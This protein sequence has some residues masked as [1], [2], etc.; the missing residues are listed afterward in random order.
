MSLS[1]C[2]YK[3]V[4]N[5]NRYLRYYPDFFFNESQENY[6]SWSG[7]AMCILGSGLF[8]WSLWYVVY[9]S[10]MHI[11]KYVFL[12][13]F[14]KVHLC[15]LFPFYVY[16][17]P[18]FSQLEE[19]SVLK[20][21]CSDRAPQCAPS[22]SFL[23]GIDWILFLLNVYTCII[24]ELRWR[25]EHCDTPKIFVLRQTFTCFRNGVSPLIQRQCLFWKST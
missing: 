22:S 9:F 6:I 2:A 21:R 19:G 13:Y 4:L 25:R 3:C 15:D 14:P 16:A 7:L 12:A 1:C 23:S 10:L 8:L 11:R 5:G 18:P 24:H 17:C 20:C